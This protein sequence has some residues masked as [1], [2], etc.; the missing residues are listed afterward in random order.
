MFQISPS[1]RIGLAYRSQ[2]NFELEGD[3][4]YRMAASAIPGVAPALT[5]ADRDVKAKLKTPANFSLAVS[6]KLSDKWEMLGDITWTDW[7]VVKTLYVN[8]ANTGAAL[9]KLP[10]NF[11]DTWR[12]GLGANYQYNDAWKLRFG[13]A[14]D[15]APVQH[16]ADRTMTLPDSDRTWLSFGAKYLL[17]KNSSLDFGYTHIFFDKTKTERAVTT[18]YPG[19]ETL[20][21]TIR[22][23]FKTSVD[24]LSLQYNHAF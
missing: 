14:H 17:S 13:I 22:G 4:N 10:Y 23:N 20:R 1:T 15:K 5:T 16:A 2:L 3:E 7:S 8:D 19:A 6:Q 12:V 24:I 11:K 18:G 21:Q 9:Q